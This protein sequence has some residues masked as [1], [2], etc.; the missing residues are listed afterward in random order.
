LNER[1]K[2]IVGR[3]ES[4]NDEL[5]KLWRRAGGTYFIPENF[6]GP[7]AVILGQ[8]GPEEREAV[9]AMIARYAR[10][11]VE[12]IEERRVREEGVGSSSVFALS[13]PMEEERL[14]RLRL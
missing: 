8:V 6:D 9:G 5:E 14:N 11:E 3:N 7:S 13:A 4:E 2:V 12:T 10:R 1:T